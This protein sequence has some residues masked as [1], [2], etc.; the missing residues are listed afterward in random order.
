MA[1]SCAEW[2]L[3]G[4]NLLVEVVLRAM[5]QRRMDHSQINRDRKQGRMKKKRKQKGG[6]GESTKIVREKA[7]EIAVERRWLGI[8][9]HILR[10]MLQTHTK[11]GWRAHTQRK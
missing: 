3:K 6:E 9:C 11:Y 7:R 4:E 5:P 1:S 10:K 2:T 8:K